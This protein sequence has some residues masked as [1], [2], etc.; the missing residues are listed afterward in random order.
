MFP[1]ALNAVSDRGGNPNISRGIVPG[2]HFFFF[3]PG[4]SFHRTFSVRKVRFL[5]WARGDVGDRAPRRPGARHS[6]EL[7]FGNMT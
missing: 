5:P 1:R 4:D 7:R 2:A 3:L 6:D